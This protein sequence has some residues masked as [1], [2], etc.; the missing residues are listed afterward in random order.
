MMH[1]P[2]SDYKLL[3]KEIRL[4]TVGKFINRY[5]EPSAPIWL[6]VIPYE[7]ST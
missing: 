6:P 5:L 4:S 7:P 1:P 3:P 2:R